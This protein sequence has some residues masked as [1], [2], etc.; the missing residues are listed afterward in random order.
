MVTHYL[1]HPGETNMDVTLQQLH[2]WPMMCSD[3][4]QHI[5][6][7]RLCQVAKQQQKK[8]SHIPPKQA[9]PAVPWNRVN[10]NL[11]GPY[12]VKTPTKVWELR[13]LTMID[14]TTGCFE[15]KDIL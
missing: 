14:L 3:I 10:V 15:A 7:C 4:H 1:A 8:Y 11:I 2:V 12:K 5:C 6:T 13:A 9:E